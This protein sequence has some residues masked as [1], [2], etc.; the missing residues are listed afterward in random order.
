LNSYFE[1]RKK[2]ASN[3]KCQMSEKKGFWPVDAVKKFGLYFTEKI[4]KR[5]I[6]NFMS[7]L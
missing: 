7:Y 4:L 3:G 5:R 2:R 6:H 1:A